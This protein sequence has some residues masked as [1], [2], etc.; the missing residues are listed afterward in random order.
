MHPKILIFSLLLLFLSIY[1][2]RAHSTHLHRR[3]DEASSSQSLPAS[4]SSSLAKEYMEFEDK[5]D[6]KKV[7]EWV[8]QKFNITPDRKDPNYLNFLVTLANAASGVK[9]NEQEQADASNLLKESASAAKKLGTIL[10][11][12]DLSGDSA[13]EALATLGSLKQASSNAL[14]TGHVCDYGEGLFKYI[15]WFWCRLTSPYPFTYH[16]SKDGQPT[17]SDSD[18]DVQKDY[19]RNRFY[20]ALAVSVAIVAAVWFLAKSAE[21]SSPCGNAASSAAKD[22]KASDTT[23]TAT[24]A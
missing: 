11:S 15:T 9:N 1:L 21:G 13:V 4:I 16:L 14:N 3:E 6:S 2:T 10:T 8:K 23:A 18:P 17:Q 7:D 12:G 22:A 20:I 24:T 5:T 19:Y